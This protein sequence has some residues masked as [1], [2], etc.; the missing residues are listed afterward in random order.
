MKQLA[1]IMGG[2]PEL[3]LHDDPS[4]G[5]LPSIIELILKSTRDRLGTTDDLVERNLDAIL[6]LS[7]WASVIEKGHVFARSLRA[8]ACDAEKVREALAI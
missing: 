7:E 3:P 4:D 5:F 1:G 6:S 2:N 8:R